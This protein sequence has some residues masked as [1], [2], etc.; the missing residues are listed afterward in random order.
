MKNG[1]RKTNVFRSS[2]ARVGLLLL[3]LPTTFI[4]Y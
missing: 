2:T 3:Q 4:C 1:L